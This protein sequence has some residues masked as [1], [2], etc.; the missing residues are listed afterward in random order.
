MK[1]GEEEEVENPLVSLTEA[2]K[3]STFHLFFLPSS[4]CLVFVCVWDRRPQSS[5]VQRVVF[6]ASYDQAAAATNGRS[7]GPA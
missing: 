3:M 7:V 5:A 2:I 6:F 1:R 4:S